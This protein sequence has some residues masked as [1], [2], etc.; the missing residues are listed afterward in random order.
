VVL[1]KMRRRDLDLTSRMPRTWDFIRDRFRVGKWYGIDLTMGVACFVLSIL[2]FMAIVDSLYAKGT[3][4]QLD[5]KIKAH[6]IRAANPGLTRLMGAITDLGSIY[7]VAMVAVIVGVTLYIRKNWWK[8]LSLFLAV[9]IGQAVL[10]ILKV[11]FQRPRPETER[12]V[13]SYS[14]PSGHVFSATVIYGFCIYLTF[15]FI[16]NAIAK[17]IVSAALI[18]LILLI[19][20]SRI[21]LGVHWFSDTL[22]GHVTGLAWLLLCILIA[23]TA[24]DR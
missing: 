16:N 7:V 22:A 12:F 4:F 20:F 18:L 3:L 2:S 5:L 1:K 10:N 13:F 14:F 19:G 11:T 21:Y 17:W 15:R 8:I 24:G 9:G 6:M 23:K